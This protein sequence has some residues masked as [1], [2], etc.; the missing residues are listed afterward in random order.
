MELLDYKSLGAA[1]KSVYVESDKYQLS[2]DVPTFELN[3]KYVGDFFNFTMFEPD[4]ERAH[5]LSHF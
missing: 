1:I 3:G 4:G 5:F 2:K